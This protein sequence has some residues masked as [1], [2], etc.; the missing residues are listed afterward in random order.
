MKPIDLDGLFDEK[1]ALYMEENKGKYTERQ[2]ENLI[3]ALY[4]KFG[5]TYVAK[6]RATPKAYYAA[7]SDEELVSTFSAHFAEHIPVPDFLCSELEK[8]DCT[9]LPF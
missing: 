6:I 1:L 2:W 4:R 9:E 3:P 5:D 8:R 7:M